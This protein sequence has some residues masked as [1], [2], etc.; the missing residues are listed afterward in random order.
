MKRELNQLSLIR[1][2]PGTPADEISNIDAHTNLIKMSREVWDDKL[3]TLT[4]AR[5]DTVIKAMVS[6]GC[7]WHPDTQVSLARYDVK[8]WG[9]R[10]RAGGT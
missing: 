6:G 7:V 10:G 3:F 8:E 1:A 4:R 2:K 9:E 5:R